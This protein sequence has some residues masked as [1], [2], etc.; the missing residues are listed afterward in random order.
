MARETEL[1]QSWSP[2]LSDKGGLL[3]GI[4]LLVGG[5]LKTFSLPVPLDDDG[6][7]ISLKDWQLGPRS[8]EAA[9][10]YSI[11]PFKGSV[12]TRFT[13]I[14]PRLDEDLS[15]RGQS[16][17]DHFETPTTPRTPRTS[18]SSSSAS[19]SK[20]FL[21]EG[22]SALLASLELST[23]PT[24][25]SESN[26]SLRSA[27]SD[28][29]PPTRSGGIAF[30]VTLE[31]DSAQITAADTNNKSARSLRVS[32]VENSR[33]PRPSAPVVRHRSP[34]RSRSLHPR[35]EVKALQPKWE[36]STKIRHP[37]SAPP[38]TK[39]APPV[40]GR[41][42]TPG[43]KPRAA[44]APLPT[45]EIE[46]ESFPDYLSSDARLLGSDRHSLRRSLD[47]SHSMGHSRGDL[48]YSTRQLSRDLTMS[49]IDDP[50]P[51]LNRSFGRRQQSAR[52][53]A[54]DDDDDDD[55][56]VNPKHEQYLC[57]TRRYQCNN[58]VI[59]M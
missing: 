36:S 52:Y 8:A 57:D 46:S 22:D 27:D 30:D 35:K 18:S 44:V 19:P 31:P 38:V 54:D 10:P 7:D 9:A 13:P 50:N 45:H 53:E 33:T 17:P 43:A 24:N 21:Q 58:M 6:T 15:P 55:D 28:Q 14:E 34:L 16:S 56:E 12:R 11:K 37:I 2:K 41:S 48:E 5:E 29:A 49:P 47:S 39:P 51:D 40:R 3:S 23:T 42:R 25:G 32:F 1:T 59:P 20:S 4:P 26:S